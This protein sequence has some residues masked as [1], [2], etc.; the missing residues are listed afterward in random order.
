M[1]IN[2]EGGDA[3]FVIFAHA[4]IT[5]SVRLYLQ[6]MQA[7]MQHSFVG[8]SKMP[9]EPSLQT[10]YLDAH[11]SR[12]LGLPKCLRGNNIT[13]AHDEHGFTLHCVGI[14]ATEIGIEIFTAFFNQ[15]RCPTRKG[16]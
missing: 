5:E 1:M 8:I 14:G 13:D 15:L 9:L 3:P 7:S 10:E 16:D 6:A 2:N 4:K 11:Q 12:R